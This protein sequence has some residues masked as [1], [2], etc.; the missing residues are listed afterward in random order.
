MLT[1]KQETDAAALDALK[2]LPASFQM[3][4]PRIL[5]PLSA[6]ID[7][8]VES[9]KVPATAPVM[10]FF[11]FVKANFSDDEYAVIQRDYLSSRSV[12][13][14]RDLGPSPEIKYLDFPFWAQSKFAIGARLKLEQYAGENILDIGA[15]PG[16]FGVVAQYFGCGY[17]GLEAQLYKMVATGRHLY[18][19]LA[20]IFRIGRITHT[21]RPF[22]RLE[23]ERRYRLVTV[24][25]GNFCSYPNP[26]GPR[27]PWGWAEWVFL[28]ENLVNDILTPAYNMYFNISRDYLPPEVVENLRKFAKTF[29]ERSCVFTFDESLDLEELRRSVPK[30]P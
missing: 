21:I 28:L 15:G 2:S 8:Y 24:L 16:H 10:K 29:D 12:E 1:D 4:V 26:P 18:D 17:D 13:S 27:K 14:M 9:A 6:M 19:D 25:M 7:S 3:H 23:L 22:K 5:L 11:D 30:G 20:R